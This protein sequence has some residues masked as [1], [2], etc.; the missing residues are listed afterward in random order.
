M[1]NDTIEA[2][3]NRCTG[4]AACS[5]LCPHHAI[6]MKA[7][8]E[9]FLVPVIQKE[10]CTDCGLCYQACPIQ[11]PP[12]HHPIEESNAW[13]AY[14]PS[15]AD[16]LQSS[17]GGLFSAFANQILAEDGVVFG[18]VLAEDNRAIMVQA[19][20]SDG[21]APMRGSKYVQGKI[22][23][24]VYQSI[25]QIAKTG[26]KV[27]FV[28][29]ACQVA[30]LFS[31][32]G[33]PYDNVY[34]IDIVCHG[35]PSPLL[36][37]VYCRTEERKQ[38]APITQYRFRDKQKGWGMRISYEVN[39]QKKYRN[40]YLDPYMHHFLLGNTYRESCY[41]CPYA[42]SARISDMTIGDYWGILQEHPDFYHGNGISL[43]LIHTP[44]GRALLEKTPLHTL[45]STF[46]QMSRHNVNLLRPTTRPQVR[47]TIYHGIQTL[48]PS[49][50]VRQR[51]KIH[52]CSKAV[53]KSCIPSWVKKG[54]QRIHR[55]GKR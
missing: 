2:V 21:I 20:A 5:A 40:G 6:E 7:N 4:C 19:N 25:R 24:D 26:K 13:A 54:I 1:H 9:G 3:G 49:V 51:L 46:A 53:I 27:L 11:T 35:V 31:F 33:K 12:L 39:H 41:Q 32:L 17:S 34:T 16:T 22:D 42:Q 30:G 48:S 18:T 38:N 50:F 8:A 14:N 29:C 15:E 28:G 44:K 10:R 45:A 55:R 47:G 52:Y 43:L 37:D 36:F 23:A